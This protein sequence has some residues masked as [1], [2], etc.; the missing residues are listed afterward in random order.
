MLRHSGNSSPSAGA[1]AGVGKGPD[2]SVTATHGAGTQH[3]YT[4]AQAQTQTQTAA[5]Y[6]R[7]SDIEDI[8]DLLALPAAA[9]TT[10]TT[11]PAAGAPAAGKCNDSL[12]D[13]GCA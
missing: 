8:L 3:G 7:I 10:I 4:G 9:T 6:R 11:A 12:R 1:I 13:C 2:G 5:L